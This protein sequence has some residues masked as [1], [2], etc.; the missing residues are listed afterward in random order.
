M[1][2]FIAHIEKPPMACPRPRATRTG[3]IYMPDKYLE[4][5][6]EV[7]QILE[8]NLSVSFWTPEESR[9]MK[10]ICKFIHK[11]PKRLGKGP[12]VVKTTRPD[13]DN[14]LKTILDCLQDAKVIKDDSFIIELS[15]VQD[16]Y[17]YHGEEPSTTIILETISGKDES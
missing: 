1:S 13:I 2:L 10:L 9:P 8:D 4:Y 7:V 16:L 14:L 6:K 5:K 15:N 3:R 11:R 17:G 12:R